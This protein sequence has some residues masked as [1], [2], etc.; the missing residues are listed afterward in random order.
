MRIAKWLGRSCDRKAA[1]VAL[2]A[3]GMREGSYLIRR[4][5]AAF[6]ISLISKGT[7][8]HMR[9]SCTPSANGA[10]AEWSIV[11]EPDVVFPTMYDLLDYHK[12][13]SPGRAHTWFLTT[14]IEP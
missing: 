2:H 13:P 10:G 9:F 8:H 1:E 12:R 6:A 3:A 11:G 5:D 14:C 7:L 4:S